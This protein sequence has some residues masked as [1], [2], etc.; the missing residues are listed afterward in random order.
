MSDRGLKAANLIEIYYNNYY[1]KSNN[2][3]YMWT[4]LRRLS[5]RGAKEKYKSCIFVF[6][7]IKSNTNYF[8]AKSLL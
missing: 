2:N 8:T 4:Q 6:L 5:E 1:V 7:N 3:I